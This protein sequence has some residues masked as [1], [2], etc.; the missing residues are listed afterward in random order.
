[1]PPKPIPEPRV[2]GST[3]TTA[4]PLAWMEYGPALP[5]PL[6]V[7]HGGPGADHRY[8]LPQMLRLAAQHDLLFY[9]QR[10]GGASTGTAASDG[11]PV[12][13][14][15]Q[16]DDLGAIVHERLGDAR[17]TIIGYSWGGLLAL[18]YLIES[19][20]GS[21]TALTP[22]DRLVLIAPAPTTRAERARFEAEFAR[23]QAAA[24]GPRATLTESGLRGR[25]PAA[26]A[27]RAFELSVSGYFADPAR[28]HDL[29]PFRI[30]GRTQ[31]SVWTSLDAYDLYPALE[32]LAA[33]GRVPPALVVHGRQDPI[34]LAASERLARTI[35]ATLVVLEDCGHVPY[36]EQP[37]ALFGAIE[38]FLAATGA[39]S[40]TPVGAAGGTA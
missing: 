21:G 12:T 7:L 15:T 10:G 36:V 34:P 24:A 25:D 32:T 19:T 8:L 23:R 9:D 18:L 3:Q 13:W 20:R 35:G 28:A 22:P 37:D 16:V 6:V 5:P 1:M 31:S 38:T 29:T 40:A 30:V 4:V 33:A 27:Q 2:A 17:P 14:R 26:Y 39:G 11:A